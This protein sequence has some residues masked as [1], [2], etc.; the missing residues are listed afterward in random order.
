MISKLQ[1][2]D[3]GR[4][5]PQPGKCTLLFSNSGVGS[6][7][8]PSSLLIKEEQRTGGL[9]LNVMTHNAVF[10]FFLSVNDCTGLRILASSLFSIFFFKHQV[11]V[12]PATESRREITH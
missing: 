12:K 5:R 3:T 10:S 11:E 7:S 8:S 6:F 9:R 1:P 2:D 4:T